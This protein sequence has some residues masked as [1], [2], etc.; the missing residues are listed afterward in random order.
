ME[1]RGPVLVL[2]PMIEHTEIQVLTEP[3]K[4]PLRPPPKKDPK[5]DPKASFHGCS[6]TKQGFWTKTMKNGV[7]R[8]SDP[9]IGPSG[10]QIGP[11]ETIPD[12]K[13]DP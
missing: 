6:P 2:M 12:P 10:P 5:M 9:Q 11:S 8:V 1:P 13:S 4:R 3:E 7:F